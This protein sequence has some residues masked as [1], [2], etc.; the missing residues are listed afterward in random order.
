MHNICN[1]GGRAVLD[2]ILT[3]ELPIP[4][5]REDEWNAWYHAEH[6]PALLDEVPAIARGTRYRR[7]DG[8]PAYGYI[9][10]YEFPSPDG[11]LAF[12]HSD[13]IGRKH[14]EYRERWGTINRRGGWE[15][16]WQM[17]RPHAGAATA[18]DPSPGQLTSTAPSDLL[19]VRLP[20]P[21]DREDEWNHWYHEQHMPSVMRQVK[22]ILVGHRFRPFDAPPDSPY[23][24]VYEFASPSA[25]KEWQ[26]STDVQQR[27]GE[28]EA[29]WGVQNTRRAFQSVFEL[30]GQAASSTSP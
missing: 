28:Y 3:V 6:M 16:V 19:T 25:L 12:M 24:V 21:T 14:R 4:P 17:R 30:R 10:I 9:V 22:G 26:T 23:F 7:L 5:G 1:G 15:R 20:V 11:M 13:T 29:Q 18:P 8:D 27:R 2:H